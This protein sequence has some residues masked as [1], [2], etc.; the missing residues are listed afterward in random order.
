MNMVDHLLSNPDFHY[1]V[2]SREDADVLY[3]PLLNRREFDGEKLRQLLN[4]NF[5]LFHALNLPIFFKQNDAYLLLA[6]R[7]ILDYVIDHKID[8]LHM[9]YFQNKARHSRRLRTR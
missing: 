4:A 2:V 9:I 3:H 7:W 5:N 8:P 1:A 6:R